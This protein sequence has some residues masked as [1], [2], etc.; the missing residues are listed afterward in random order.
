MLAISYTQATS[1]KL[2]AIKT[3]PTNYDCT[4]A[5]IN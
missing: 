4:V 2:L 5:A 3:T 1:Y